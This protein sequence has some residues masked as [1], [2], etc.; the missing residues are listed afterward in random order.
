MKSF[1]HILLISPQNDCTEVIKQVSLK[2][3]K[4]SSIIRV[5]EPS[6]GITVLNK[7]G[8]VD[9]KLPVC[10][11]L[12]TDT[13]PSKLSSFLDLL[14][15]DYPE[16]TKGKVVLVNSRLGLSSLMKLAMSEAVSQFI[17]CP[18]LPVEVDSV[19]RSN[20]SSSGTTK[21]AYA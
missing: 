20:A 15:R 8:L 18:V 16:I 14:D 12:N 11:F 17:N 13:E 7:I 3:L 21:T 10:I 1:S 4:E 2:T 19:L 6:E 5:D 9:S